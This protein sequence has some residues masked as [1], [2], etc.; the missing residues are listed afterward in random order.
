MSLPEEE[1]KA[2]LT[3]LNIIHGRF[4]KIPKSLSLEQLYLIL[5]LTS[6]A[7]KGK[8]GVAKLTFVAWEL[9]QEQIFRTLVD[10]LVIVCSMD[11]ESRLTTPKGRCFDDFDHFG[12]NDLTGKSGLVSITLSYMS[13]VKYTE[14]SVPS[15][16]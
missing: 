14:M 13:H 1:P 2:L 3:V 9:G 5:A 16:S 6:L 4:A 12:P 15:Y 8:G 11:S 7:E 10:D